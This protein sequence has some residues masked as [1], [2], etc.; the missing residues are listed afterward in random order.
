MT[1]PVQS[2]KVTANSNSNLA[3]AFFLL[4]ET[5]RKAMTA[6]YAFC[7]KVDDVVDNEG[8]SF[9]KRS[10]DL[11]GWR[12]DISLVCS[13]SQSANQI[14]NELSAYIE[15]Y[16]LSFD[17]FDEL[18]VGMETD[19]EK[20]RYADY[21]E[22]KLYCHRAASV[23]GLLTVRILGFKNGDADSY[24]EHIGQALQLT[25]IL[26]DISEDAARGRIYLPQS[27]LDKYGVSEQSVLDG[28]QSS[29][30]ENAARELADR[31]WAHY[32]L[33]AEALPKNNYRDLLVLEAMASIYWRLLQKMQKI[34]FNVLS[35]QR[36]KIRLGKWSKLAMG[37]QIRFFIGFKGYRPFYAR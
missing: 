22:L 26:R 23:V 35:E 34:N 32:K 1:E 36:A 33:T 28:E 14:C 11:M 31:A 2:T 21:Q 19:L 8:Q 15:Q 4:P 37:I 30:F 16:E 6:L 3:A 18:I 25:N 24:A 10:A 13:G 7:R 29:G 20:V 27:L 17:L 5:K 9:A 12:N